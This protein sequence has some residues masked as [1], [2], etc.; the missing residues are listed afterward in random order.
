M[1]LTQQDTIQTYCSNRS[2][3][4]MSEDSQVDTT[5]EIGLIKWCNKNRLVPPQLV[6]YQDQNGDWVCQATHVMWQKDTRP[7]T[8]R[9]LTKKQAHMSLVLDN[10][11][12]FKPLFDLETKLN[13]AKEDKK[14]HL[15][16]NVHVTYIDRDPDK[17]NKWCKVSLVMVQFMIFI[18]NIF[19]T[20]KFP[21]SD[22]IA[23]GAIAMSCNCQPLHSVWWH[24]LNLTRNVHF[25]SPGVDADHVNW[26][27]RFYRFV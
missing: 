14:H 8:S 15:R 20:R 24:V 27:T 19:W 3:D 1:L 9:A 16:S 7:I 10:I 12:Q 13:Q 4:W 22:G 21:S 11:D 5:D 23:K 6:D 2:N 26:H 25:T 17:I 18:R